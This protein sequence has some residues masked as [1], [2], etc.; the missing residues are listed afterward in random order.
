MSKR[1]PIKA[2]KELADD[3]LLKQ[4]IIVAWDGKLTHVVTYG[5]T[6]E[7]CDQA[8]QGGNFVKKALRWPESL[9]TEPSRVKSLKARIKELE[10]EKLFLAMARNETLRPT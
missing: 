5:K 7:D 1:I 9:M 4:V 2:A 10:N 3:F 8:A 6:L